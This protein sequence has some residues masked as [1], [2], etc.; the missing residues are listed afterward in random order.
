MELIRSNRTEQLA[1][2]L[3]SLVRDEPLGAFDS[4]A[5][6]VQS[7]GM[8]R[9]LTLALASRLGVW[10]N[11]SFPFPRTAIERVL[12]DLD[13][14]P[15]ERS[16]AYDPARLKWT[17]AELLHEEAPPM[18]HEYL[19]QTAD[20]D[21]VLRLSSSLSVMFDGYVVYRPEM[22]HG[23]IAGS[24]SQWQAELW[25][26]IANRLGPHDL[27]SRIKRAGATLRSGDEALEIR[28][29]RLH[30]FSLETLPPLFLDFFA[31]LSRSIRT[32]LYLLTPT[33]EYLSNVDK[34]G[35]L[36][37]AIDPL[38]RDGHPLL[39]SLGSLAR[40]F[41]ELLLEADSN[42]RRDEDLFTLPSR[43]TLLGSLQ[44]D[45]LEF[46]GPPES[47]DK[48][49]ITAS[50][51]SIAVHACASPMREVLVLHDIICGALE[52]DPTLRPED[53]VVMARD[54]DAYA[55]AFRAVFGQ[56]DVTRIPYEVHDRKT[57]DDAGFYD[58]F[59]SVL[60][61]LESRFSVLD[62]VR[63]MDAQSWR[64]D[65]RFSSNERARLTDLLQAAGI[66][67]GIDAKHRE[68]LGFPPESLH[69]WRAGFGRLF[70]GFASMPNNAEVF[71]GLLPRGELSLEDVEL[72]ARLSRLC[73]VLFDFRERMHRP[74]KVSI[75]VDLLGQL[76]S[77][78]FA[79]EDDDS[80]A[81]RVLRSSLEDLRQLAD[82]SGY[83]GAI[84][85]RTIRRE[86]AGV[87]LRG[88]PPAGFL[89]RGVTLSELVPLRSIPFRMVCL[90]GMSGESFP[91][92]DDRPSFDLTRDKPRLGDRSK[93][94]DDR[95]SFLQA[96]LCARDRLAITYSAPVT[97]ARSA[98]TPSTVV[99]E[100]EDTL[101]R[102]YHR[103][104]SES[105]LAPIEHPLH[106]FD[107]AY[108]TE[109][110]FLSSF[111]E[112]HLRIARTMAQ[113]PSEPRPVELRAEL[114]TR[115]NRVS[116]AELAK[117]IWHPAREFIQRRLGTRFDESTLYE[118]TRALTELGNLDAFRVGNDALERSLIGE[119]LRGFLR[120][121][122]EFPEGSW[123]EIGRNQLAREVEALLEGRETSARPAE[124]RTRAVTVDLD[125][126]TVEGRLDGL[127]TDRRVKLRFSKVR[128]KTEL[129][130]W[131]EHLLMQASDE[132]DLPRTT[133]LVL[134]ATDRRADVVCFAPVDDA[135][136]LLEHLVK[137]Y[138]ASQANPVPLLGQPS[139]VFA[140][141]MIHDKAG[142]ALEKAKKKQREQ[143]WDRYARFAW[144]KAGPFANERW[145]ERFGPT[146]S[147][148]YEPL[149][150]HRSLR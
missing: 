115:E 41:Q 36:S 73:N 6:V 140:D 122:P 31:A 30:L 37:L 3:A 28:F 58:D 47:A 9:W 84:P 98:A 95:H 143:T 25:R 106:A 114:K 52:D 32:H 105:V 137:L 149:F 71:N 104:G 97:S 108:F 132:P 49:S 51:D 59:L 90:I 72:L 133:E 13:L 68:E 94:H 103:G 11:P 4:E 127:Y 24:Q 128:T 23:W 85:L 40:D 142:Q 130:T 93:R 63:L 100:L 141:H 55:P 123:G 26:R 117:W 15:T 109:G 70:L 131:L 148:V 2:A 134:R 45:I 66:R 124:E 64:E 146:S 102:Y 16:K 87:V 112:R 22:L 145:A 150:R 88:T 34:A 77:S 83:G 147:S 118:P 96:I 136:T 69:T 135:R 107:Q 44:A 18:L 129:T 60:E 46:R 61:V 76:S 91:R 67:W 120:A 21:R 38:A 14:G 82:A 81:V 53:I 79:E 144:G 39:M 111:S 57:R 89:R 20:P 99:C 42:V 35:Q 56:T 19:G 5:I 65:F 86:L 92:A 33:T 126:I 48:T 74:A 75:W 12:D 43:A 101:N 29:K 125:G 80:G 116:I 17:I 10:S 138:E 54:L 121:A 7:R 139:W 50:D 8:E 27:A 1:D 113:P 110:N 78:L 62:V 119:E